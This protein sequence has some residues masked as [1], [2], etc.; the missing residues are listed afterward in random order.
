LPD[1][2]GAAINVD[3]PA[4]MDS[5]PCACAGVGVWN[6]SANQRWTNG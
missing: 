2:V 6:F 5:Q 1:P 3:F 4:A